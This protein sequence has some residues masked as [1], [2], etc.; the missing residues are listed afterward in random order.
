MYFLE[1]M[2]KSSFLVSFDIIINHFFPEK[3]IETPKFP[4]GS[5]YMK[6]LFF[7]INYS[8][9]LPTTLPILIPTREKIAFKKP[10]LITDNTVKNTQK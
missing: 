10:S 8:D 9:P 1:N 3:L 7:N 4:N 6:I 2:V 5:E